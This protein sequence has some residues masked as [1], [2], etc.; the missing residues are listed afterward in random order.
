MK[1]F[2][3]RARAWLTGHSGMA[4]YAT[5]LLVAVLVSLNAVVYALTTE[6]GLY[7]YS[8][9]RE[10]APV[11]DTSDLYF[12]RAMLG[13]RQVTVTF[14]DD[15]KNVRDH[16]TGSFVYNTAV[17]M[18]EKHPEFIKLRFVNAITGFDAEGNFIDLSVY[19]EDGTLPIYTTSIIFECEGNHRVLTGGRTGYEDFYTLTSSG[20]IYAYN[21]E[22]VLASMI[23]W[24]TESEHKTVYFTQNH[25]EMA[26]VSLNSALVSAGYYVE[27][28]N[29]RKNPVPDDAALVI[30][31]NPTADFEISADG[32]DPN[33]ELDRLGR[34]LEKGG[35]LYVSLDPFVKK[36][37]NLEAFLAARGFAL[38][39]VTDSEGNVTREIVRD[40]V[41]GIPPDGYSFVTTPAE[42]EHATPVFEL[43]SKYVDGGVLLRN[44]GHLRL[45]D[46]AIPLLTSSPS[47]VAASAGKVTNSDG[48]YNVVGYNR[49]VSED[50]GVSQIVVV[51]SIYISS[52]EAMVNNSYTNKAFMI[53]LLNVMFEATASPM[54]C[55]VT[56]YES[57]VLEDFTMGRARLYTAIILAI[58]AALAVTGAVIIIRRKNR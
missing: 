50:G 55:T 52:T 20:S 3:E 38:G 11:S 9:E 30:I 37:N 6:Y 10:N 15:E 13:G 31:S 36:L 1:K 27:I 14:C 40:D 33:A 17:A 34:Y 35:N 2:S 41:K 23:C 47:S 43:M 58:P 46:G 21:G 32:S 56:L 48:S 18:A 39:E 57:S 29:L 12:E 54:G 26:D 51:P 53:S 16:D 28:I 5:V 45:S 8:P 44:S 7:L 4:F 49:I 19:N 42:N 24:V 22:E 25:G